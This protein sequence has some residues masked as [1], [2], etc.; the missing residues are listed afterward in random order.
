M[1]S[2]Q[3]VTSEYD[4][5][6]KGV[7]SDVLLRVEEQASTAASTAV[8]TPYSTPPPQLQPPQPQPQ[9]QPQPHQQ[10]QQ[11]QPQLE[12]R[13]AE[14][15]GLPTQYP[16]VSDDSGN[17]DDL[18]WGSD[19]S[20]G[21]NGFRPLPNSPPSPPLDEELVYIYTKSL[22]PLSH[23]PQPQPQQLQATH[24]PIPLSECTP[25]PESQSHSHSQPLSPSPSPTHVKRDDLPAPDLSELNRGGIQ[26][27]T[28]K[29]RRRLLHI[30]AERNRRL[31]QNKMYEELYRLVPGLENSARSTKREVLTK[32]ADWLED[33][34][35]ENKRLE[36]QLRILRAS[37]SGPGPGTGIGHDHGRG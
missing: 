36:E 17:C 28:G 3:H 18:M 31:N 35:E 1:S 5:F 25:F 11:Q 4:Y 9:P 27:I 20:F 30:I 29:K 23:H 32:T 6:V 19:L 21:P 13:G 12:P 37:P 14:N 2:L 7:V 10:Q 26:K 34:V 16:I 15:I 8:P 22:V 24:A 33:L